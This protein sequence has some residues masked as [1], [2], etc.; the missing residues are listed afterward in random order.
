MRD[1]QPVGICCDT[2][3]PKSVF[4]NNLEGWVGEGG[5]KEAQEEGDVC[6]PM[7]DSCCCMAETI[8]NCKAI[9]Q[10]KN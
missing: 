5:G 6:I 4:C 10:I 1:R 7:A 3:I 2:E 8:T 9:I